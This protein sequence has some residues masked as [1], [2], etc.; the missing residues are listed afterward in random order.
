MPQGTAAQK[1]LRIVFF[2][3]THL[4]FDYPIKPRVKRRRRGQDFF[5]NFHRVFSFAKERQAHFVIHGGD[6]FFRSRIP[7]KIEELVVQALFDYAREGIKIFIVPGNHERSSLPRHLLLTH[8][9]IR[10]F[11]KP[12]TFGVEVGGVRVSLSGFPCVRDDIRGCWV[13]RVEATGWREHDG[14]IRLL[15]IHQSVEGA[16][17]G[18]S[19]FTF[20]QGKDVVPMRMVPE[21]FHAVLSGHIHRRQILRTRPEGGIPVIYPGSIERT[22][23]AEKDED[24]GFYEIEFSESGSHGMKLDRLEFHALPTR[25]MIDIAL[26]DCPVD[27]DLAAFL[28]K[29]LSRLDPNAIVRLTI[30][31][32]SGLLA[33]KTVEL[34]H[35]LMKRI[36]PETMNYQFSGALSRQ[37][38]KKEAP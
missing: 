21:D 16:Q 22:S 33:R 12:R 8:E 25:S 5:D 1:K 23:F 27:T 4:G 36:I 3:D 24:K 31:P 10:I 35:A 29:A 30:A 32:D 13:E 9:N 2:A 38:A 14:H 28:E 6:L 11:D 20:R 19:D 15:C 18:P 34:T 17:V 7:R 37:W 26:D